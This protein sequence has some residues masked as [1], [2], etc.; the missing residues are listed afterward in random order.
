[1]TTQVYHYKDKNGQ[2]VVPADKITMD[3]AASLGADVLLWTAQTVPR[4]SLSPEGHY[5]PI[6]LAR[7]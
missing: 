5:T 2:V 7:D 4:A 1:M 6:G 3:R